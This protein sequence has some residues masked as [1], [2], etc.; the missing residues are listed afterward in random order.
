MSEKKVPITRRDFLKFAGITATAVAGGTLGVTNLLNKKEARE[1]RG[2][3]YPALCHACGYGCGILVQRGGNNLSLNG[4]PL[5]TRNGGALC[6]RGYTRI[7]E[8]IS[9]KNESETKVRYRPPGS[10]TWQYISM[11][12]ALNRIARRMKDTR[13]NTFSVEKDGFHLA[14]TDAIFWSISASLKNEELYAWKKMALLTGAA[15]E[16]VDR[17]YLNRDSLRELE[18][19]LGF[20]ASTNPWEDLGRADS[21]LVFGSE[22]IMNQSV[23][24][25]SLQEAKDRGAPLALVDSRLERPAS[26][27]TDFAG[28]R[29]GTEEAF[30]NGIIAYALEKKRYHPDY[31]RLHTNATCLLHPDFTPNY[32]EKGEN[33]ADRSTWSYQIDRKGIPRKDRSLDNRY[34]VMAAMEKH[35]SWYTTKRVAKITGLDEGY[36][37]YLAHMFTEDSTYRTLAILLPSD[38]NFPRAAAVLQLVLGNIGVHGGGLYLASR[39]MNEAGFHAFR[40]GSPD[41]PGGLESP[42]FGTDRDIDSYIQ[43]TVKVSNDPAS[44]NIRGE[45]RSHLVS[46]LRALYGRAAEGKSDY[47]FAWLPR[48]GT[49]PGPV[50]GGFIIGSDTLNCA[51]LPERSSLEWLVCLDRWAGESATFWKEEPESPTEVFLLPTAAPLEYEGSIISS[52]RRV[53]WSNPAFSRRE[54][55]PT[56]LEIA[57]SLFRRLQDMYRMEGGVYPEP[58]LYAGWQQDPLPRN[59]F[60]EIAGY[61][62]RGK[63]LSGYRELSARGETICGNWTLCGSAGT[64]ISSAEAPRTGPRVRVKDRPDGWFWPLGSQY[65]YNRAGL[66]K[67]GRPLKEGK[68]AIQWN[69]SKWSRDI[70]DGQG[71]PGKKSAF[72]ALH[73]GVARIFDPRGLEAPLP[74]YT[75]KPI[76]RSPVRRDVPL[77]MPMFFFHQ[78][79]RRNR[80]EEMNLG[81]LR[82]VYPGSF[83]EVDPRTG[84]ELDLKD[85][86]PVIFT[87]G[88]TTFRLPVVITPRVIG[89]DY[90]G[91]ETRP[92]VINL[93]YE[94]F[95]RLPRGHLPARPRPECILKKGDIRS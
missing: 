81:L 40:A 67:R 61:T 63:P 66:D 83:M 3:W 44:E 82:E 70:P 38:A 89:L 95:T 32:R 64:V 28:I 23:V 56:F 71:E 55:V 90:Y 72:T 50:K 80:V 76:D 43:R 46:L 26:L 93:D 49:L 37:R 5:S 65:L 4:D 47:A 87:M 36:F 62:E 24:N 94:G 79:L 18:R 51:P 6:P 42:R 8:Y 30:I 73:E 41:L 53:R 29:R 11:D 19:T 92:L 13:D 84:R 34:S 86:D 39:E 69:G 33:G 58:L 75:E 9:R 17:G 68:N 88:E 54:E 21:V 85:G 10:R 27:A 20:A 52:D 57:H 48:A 14:R 78:P 31:L 25:L 22:T 2:T 16:R 15:P 77:Y 35:Y 45:S 1:S 59:V 12:D 74:E 91:R 60:R 7:E